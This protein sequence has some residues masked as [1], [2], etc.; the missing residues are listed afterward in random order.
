MLGTT[1]LPGRT[2]LAL[3][4][5]STLGCAP[6][7]PV[8]ALQT[9]QRVVSWRS[10]LQVDPAGPHL[11][12]PRKS[13]LSNIANV[14]FPCHPCLY[15][16]FWVTDSQLHLHDLTWVPY[17]CDSWHALHI[18]ECPLPREAAPPEPVA[19]DI[20][21]E[22][23]RGW[24]SQ[25]WKGLVSLCPCCECQKWQNHSSAPYRSAG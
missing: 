1:P 18:Q 21:T 4:C 23:S 10:P 2:A 15:L 14:C 24:R 25:V 20:G 8:S 6:P 12:S 17:L 13:G 11:K 22:R 16:Q 19:W 9:Q 3:K 5:F 7:P